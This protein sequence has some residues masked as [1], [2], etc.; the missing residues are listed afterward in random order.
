[1]SAQPQPVAA[2]PVL[3]LVWQ[4]DPLA[5][6]FV[7]DGDGAV[8]ADGLQIGA[9]STVDVPLVGRDLEVRRVGV[10]ELV[11]LA[12]APPAGI[13]LGGSARVL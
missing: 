6:A 5:L 12:A 13:A 3:E 2:P 1:M 8:S 4:L 7:R 11:A 10:H 9:A